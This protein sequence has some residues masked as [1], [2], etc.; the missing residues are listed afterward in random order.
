MPDNC[1]IG[2]SWQVHVH[3]LSAKQWAPNLSHYYS[4]I[5]FM[6]AEEITS[7]IGK[8]IGDGTQTKRQQTPNLGSIF[9][10]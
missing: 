5:S 7:T 9:S 2:T 3:A 4:S 8:S 1:R 6:V 10:A